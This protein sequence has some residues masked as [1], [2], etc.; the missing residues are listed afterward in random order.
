MRPDFTTTTGLTLAA[1][2]AADLNVRA[3]VIAST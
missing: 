2:R 1:A 3:A